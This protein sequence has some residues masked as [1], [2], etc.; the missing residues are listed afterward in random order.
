MY[1]VPAGTSFRA[2]AGF[3]TLFGLPDVQSFRPFQSKL[4]SKALAAEVVRLSARPIVA[5]FKIW[6]IVF[7]LK[8]FDICKSCQSLDWFKSNVA[9]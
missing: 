6:F 5:T 8:W 1:L 4:I 9:A 7:L 2:K 3:A